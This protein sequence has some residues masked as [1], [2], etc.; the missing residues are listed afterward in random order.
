[1]LVAWT[2]GIRPGVGTVSNM[3]LIGL[4]VDLVLRWG[5]LPDQG[6]GLLGVRVAMLGGALLLFGVGSGAYIAPRLGAGPR[7]SLMLALAVRTGR[8]VYAGPGRSS[9]RRLCGAG[10]LLGWGPSASAPWSPWCCW[11]PLVHAGLRLFGF[12]LHAATTTTAPGPRPVAAGRRPARSPLR[13]G[14]AAILRPG[15]SRWRGA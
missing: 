3:L 14:V 12:D 15:S 1:M 6:S 10:F 11:D 9:N 13:R 7:D 2:L 8:P 5:W 4:W